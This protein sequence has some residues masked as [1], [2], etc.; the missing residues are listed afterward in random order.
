M[1]V[2]MVTSSYPLFEG[3]GT[4]PF[5]EEIARGVAARGHQVDV[6]LP[7]H[8]KLRRAAEGGLRFFPFSYAPFASL[9]VWGYAQSMNADR[10]FKGKTLLVA[11]FAALATTGAVRRRLREEA[12]DIVHAHWVVPGGVLSRG[13]VVARGKPFVISLH[14]S[15]VFAAERSRLV[16]IAARRAFLAAGAV[17]A[18]SSDLRARAI[19]LGAP[20]GSTHTVPYGVDAAFFGG[21]TLAHDERDAMR[22]RLGAAPG[23]ILVVAVGRLVEKKGFAHL[24][25]A[26][27]GSSQ[28]HVAIVG[29][30]DLHE[31][32]DARARAS[33]S[34]V[35][36]AGR[37]SRKETRD[38]L[39]SADIVAVPSI[40]D[41]KGNVDGLPN[42]LLEAM[43]SGRAILASR[44]AGI[45]DVL[46]DGVEG[47][48]VPPGDASSIREGL[49]RLA[50]SVS[51]RTHL[52]EGAL[53]RVKRDLTWER[54][55]ATLEESYVQARTLAKH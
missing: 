18:C 16:G 32:L 26:V 42:T 39:D 33:R 17:T 35:T 40:V 37:F 25:E 34:S 52:G 21:A 51:L 50:S 36:L 10:G 3:D 41:S 1:K 55:A 5:I 43:A 28:L 11:P 9:N 27:G 23:R 19:A 12:Y 29:D 13:P 15:D 8:P 44:V 54:V 4:A 47:L 22:R 53:R 2:L 24:I 7:S 20:E 49:L 14:G 31:N 38:A 45:P 46:S 30:G 6:V 48:L